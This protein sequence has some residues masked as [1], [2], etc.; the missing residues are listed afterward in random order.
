MLLEHDGSLLF[1]VLCGGI[2]MYSI[3]F[4]L[5]ETEQVAY[6]Q[7]GLPYLQQLAREVT[8]QPDAFRTRHSQNFDQLPGFQQAVSAWRAS[9][10]AAR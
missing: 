7:Q 2:A 4:T 10:A 6:G 3:D 1:T 9:N 5:S 8:L